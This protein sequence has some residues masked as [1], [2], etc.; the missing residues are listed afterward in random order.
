VLAALAC[1]VI[2]MAAEPLTSLLLWRPAAIK[3]P[4]QRISPY[5]VPPREP[6]AP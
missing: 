1:G 4:G 6:T 2:V 3:V 5:T